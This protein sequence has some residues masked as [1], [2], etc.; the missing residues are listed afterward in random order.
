MTYTPPLPETHTLGSKGTKTSTLECKKKVQKLKI[1]H[2][3]NG[4]NQKNPHTPVKLESKNQA[5]KVVA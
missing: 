2:V 3:K 5:K 1:S 4:E